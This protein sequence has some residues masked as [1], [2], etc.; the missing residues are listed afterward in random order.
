M[1]K[2]SGIKILV[3]LELIIA[4]LGVATG[5]NLLADPS[6]KSMGLDVVIDKVPLND[7]TLLGVWFIGPYGLLPALLA[8]GFWTAKSWARRLALILASIELLWVIGQ[9]YFVGTHVFQ[10]IIGAIA[11]LT[12]YFLFRSTVKE[13]LSK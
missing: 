4:I 1:A 8:Y 5:I 12:I 9:I 11:L 13:Y 10:A 7:F 6:G 3:V 2:P